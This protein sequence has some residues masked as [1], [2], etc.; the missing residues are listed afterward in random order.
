LHTVAAH[1][2]QQ[3]HIASI[4]IPSNLRRSVVADQTFRQLR[5][6][7]RRYMNE[8]TSTFKY[9]VESLRNSVAAG[10]PIKL[11]TATLFV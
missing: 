6:S 2:R 11:S 4:N 7:K 1:I 9:A 3:W 5:G 8:E 10:E